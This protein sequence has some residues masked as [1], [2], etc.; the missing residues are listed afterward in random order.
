MLS[1]DD[2]LISEKTLLK[3]FQEMQ[4]GHTYSQ[5]LER[6]A[7]EIPKEDWEKLDKSGVELDAKFAKGASV[8]RRFL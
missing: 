4:E 3:I 8:L 2:R 6:L 1:F 7:L 5:A